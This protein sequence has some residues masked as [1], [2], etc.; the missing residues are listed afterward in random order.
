MG[1]LAIF[2][3]RAPGFIL[4]S[5]P[6][7]FLIVS[8]LLTIVVGALVVTLADTF[9]L[10]GGNLGYIFAFNAGSLIFVDLL[11]IQVR[12]IIGEEPGETIDSDD[13]IEAKTRTEAQKIVEKR[14][15]NVVA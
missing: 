4:F 10:S 12:K 3:V 14:I 8:V 2:S 1:E 15:R 9:S 5:L 7:S 11:K 6:S 13:L